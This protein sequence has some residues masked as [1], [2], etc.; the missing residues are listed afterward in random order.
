M[1]RP[2]RT[3][4]RS[5]SRSWTLNLL[6]AWELG[7]DGTPL[8]YAQRTLAHRTMSERYRPHVE[9]LL[10]TVGR[11]LAEIDAAIV[12]HASNWRLERLHA[13]DRNI[14]R[15]GIAE[16]RWFDDVP[17]R[18]TIHE[19]LKL[20]HRYGSPGSP[21]FLNGVLDAVRKAGEVES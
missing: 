17:P 16:L 8:A 18:V 14:L 9:R 6:Y 4:V 20:A 11:N 3:H 21:R 7:G 1:T 2:A 5:R 10:D 12:R 19:A 13:I 15:I